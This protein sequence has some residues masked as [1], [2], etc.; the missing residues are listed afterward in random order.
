VGKQIHYEIYARFGGGDYA[1]LEAMTDRAK[2]LKLA[3]ETLKEGHAAAV[4]VM[5]ETFDDAT[6]EFATLK[7]FED[8]KIVKT[9]KK[10]SKLDDEDAAPPLPCFKPDDLYS[11]HARATMARMLSDALARM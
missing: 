2:A 1:L 10:P 11:V 5:K 8:G 6:G 7:I 9:V 4:K 3:E